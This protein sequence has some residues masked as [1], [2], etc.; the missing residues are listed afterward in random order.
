MDRSKLVF[1]MFLMFVMQ[2]G[3]AQQWLW[4]KPAGGSAA[5]MAHAAVTD[6]DGNVFVTG[7][8]EGTGTFGTTQL[9]NSGQKDVFIVKY[10]NQGTVQW[11]K[12]GGGTGVE[13][14]LSVAVD[15]V[16]DCYITG[17]FTGT[18]TFGSTNLTSSNGK[19]IFMAKYNG[20]NGNLVWAKKIGVTGDAEGA[21]I[22]LDSA[23]AIYLTGYFRNTATFKPTPNSITLTAAGGLDA[24]VAKF[25][26]SGT[27]LWARKAGGSSLDRAYGISVCNDQVLVTGYY[28]GAA[29]F[30]SGTL[31]SAG[32]G[33]AFVMK[34]DTAGT[35]KWAKSYGGTN[36]DYGHTVAADTAGNV[37]VAGRF[38]IEASFGS[39][40]LTSYGTVD[41]F[42]TKLNSNGNLQWV[43][44][45]G[46]IQFDYPKSIQLNKYY[47]AL[48]MTG[49]YS[50]AATFGTLNL[51]SVT[52]SQDVFVCKT[53]TS[54]NV[55][56]ATGGGGQFDDEGN[57][58]AVDTFGAVYVAGGFNSSNPTFGSQNV[59][60]LGGF[61]AFTG[62]I[63]PLSAQIIKTDVSCNG[64]T[65]GSI[66]IVPDG[67]SPPFTYTWTPNVSTNDTVLNL[68]AGS[69]SI[70]VEDNGGCSATVQAVI[71]APAPLTF[72]ASPHPITCHNANN[73]FI[74]T[75]LSGGTAPFT[76]VWNTNPVQTN[77]T[78][79]NLM[80]GTYTVTVTDGGGCTGTAQATI[81]NPTALTANAGP[82][83]NVCTGNAVT[84]GGSPVATGGSSPYTYNWSPATYLS[85]SNIATPVATPLAAITYT[86]TATD[87]SGCTAT[88]TVAIGITQPPAVMVTQNDTICAGET[89]NLAANAS[90]ALGYA[91]SPAA[92]LNNAGIQT[93]VASPAITTTYTVTVTF[94]GNCYNTAQT[95]IV[96]NPLPQITTSGNQSICDGD[97]LQLS[98]NGGSVYV[99][100]PANLLYNNQVGSPQTYP[101][102]QN[103]T[104]NVSVTDQNGCH[105]TASL[106]ITVNPVP[107]PA[108]TE[109]MGTLTSN[110]AVGNQW[111]LNNGIIN[112]A[113]SQNYTPSQNGDYTVAVTL[114]NCTGF[115][116]PFTMVNVGTN[117]VQNSIGIS[118]YPNPAENTLYINHQDATNTHY[119]Y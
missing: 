20:S 114:F 104:F 4:V 45:Y 111:Y 86:L 32:S 62:K 90:N 66:I 78:A 65:D 33:D 7:S 15:A 47:D 14:G 106:L 110:Y 95:T 25:N 98:A 112:G 93:P 96:V 85:Q 5:D 63:C 51:T 99:W 76:Y 53:D 88:S 9:T 1:A 44:K 42:L 30:G 119:R 89:S 87:A 52:N 46:G 105:N 41:V 10:N 37:Y 49:A 92:S 2:A 64:L 24:F 80:A 115:S 26:T 48:Y 75:T 118:I 56:W 67:G 55:L 117:E 28:E 108:I 72:S 16:G 36:T 107:T 116:Q 57:G 13:E 18:V 61:D 12:K 103:T 101:L 17:Y 19:D 8:Y 77:D 23:G 11:A 35:F 91:W 100:Q 71:S 68:A 113:T 70:V 40:Q 102:T 6:Y 27:C 74:S 94:S 84:L 50:L 38:E 69:Y 58:I 109:N 82:Q 3:F 29:S 31:T 43:K 81:V 39:T 54:G 73:G 34:Y 79:F 59:T 22:A 97:S 21:G 83:S 60:G